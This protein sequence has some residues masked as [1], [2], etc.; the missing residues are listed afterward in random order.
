MKKNFLNLINEFESTTPY[1]PNTIV[2]PT[3]VKE[4]EPVVEPEKTTQGIDT[5]MVV[6]DNAYYASMK[7]PKTGFSYNI[8]MLRF[9]DPD[10]IYKYIEYMKMKET[11]PEQFERL[12]KWA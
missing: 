1:V 9:D 2:V 10:Y 5:E 11:H 4:I 12:L 8:P 7:D 3:E 6:K